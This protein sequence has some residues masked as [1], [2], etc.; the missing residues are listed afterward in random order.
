M[1]TIPTVSF[2]KNGEASKISVIWNRSSK[3]I[4][5]VCNA[6]IPGYNMSIEVVLGE[7]EWPGIAIQILC[8]LIHIRRG[9]PSLEVIYFYAF[10]NL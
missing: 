1:A 7:Q 9:N 8:T 6:K 10:F 5:I 2:Y 3:Q 4:P